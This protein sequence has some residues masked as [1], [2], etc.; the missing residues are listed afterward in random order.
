MKLRYLLVIILF[1]ISIVNIEHIFPN[2]SIKE[3][4]ITNKVT[5]DSQKL[6]KYK[7]KSFFLYNNSNNFFTI[8]L[9]KLADFL[10][11]DPQIKSVQ[12]VKKWPDQLQVKVIEEKLVGSIGLYFLTEDGVL[13]E[14]YK[15]VQSLPV[16]DA[17]LVESP[18]IFKIISCMKDL[19]IP[20]SMVKSY[21]L[22]SW[23]IITKKGQEIAILKNK[24]D[25]H[26]ARFS[27]VYK[28]ELKNIFS[29]IASM[30]LRYSSSIA[31]NWQKLANH[32]IIPL[33]T[34]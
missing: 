25:E 31:I 24:E 19:E 27:K 7:I 29:K 15:N 13:I 16:L 1:I 32:P 34:N 33:N 11:S 26:L 12:F 8:K 5:T 14:K 2:A 9:K 4:L 28:K 23:N 22:D 20:I 6:I 21:Q 10:T 3:I 18:Q 30:D 17:D